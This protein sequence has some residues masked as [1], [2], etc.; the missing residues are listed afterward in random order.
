MRALAEFAMRGRSYAIGLSMVGAIVPLMS[1]VSGA[2]VSLV[3]LRKGGLDGSIVLLW[4]LLPLGLS[5]YFMGDP[6]S[7]NAVIGA[8]ILAY[9]LRVTVSWE[10]TLATT[11][12]LS[13]IASL[14][15]QYTAS[16]VLILFVNLYIEIQKQFS[17]EMTYESAEGQFLG[18]FAML[19]AY[20]MFAFL[21]LARW[22]QSQLYN[23]G[24]FKLEFHQIRVTP[25]FSSAILILIIACVLFGESLSRWM[26]LLTMPLAV[27]G[28]AIVH[29]IVN[30][31]SLS[32]AWVL[33]FYLLL[34]FFFQLIY[35]ILTVLALLDGYLNIRQRLLINKV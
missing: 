4:T 5:I 29:W 2:I 34:I 17:V 26:P 1:W 19:Q 30:Y 20:M 10:L 12:V 21:I 13:V 18:G 7:A 31:R 16:D 8:A 15:F 11:L 3:F 14:V 32:G 22:W 27:S 23:P 25:I 28:L 24:E 9:V 33:V 6:S 35:P